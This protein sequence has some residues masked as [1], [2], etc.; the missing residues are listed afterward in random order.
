MTRRW[1]LPALLLGLAIAM[2]AL[3]RLTEDTV[4]PAAAAPPAVPPASRPLAVTATG[5]ANPAAPA[6]ELRLGN[7]VVVMDT[8]H[9]VLRAQLALSLRLPSQT[10]E[11]QGSVQV[12]G[13]P[14]L[15]SGG[16]R[17]Y[18]DKPVR[19]E[20]SLPGLPAAESARVLAALDR[21]IPAFFQQ[22][23]VFAP[24]E[25]ALTVPPLHQ[26]LE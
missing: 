21:A 7:P 10:Q 16:Q 2:T 5:T 9:A 19:G 3:F 25:P 17:F 11:W 1:G 13:P 6:G 8:E 22:R 18:L 15:D 26:P 20:V 24:A 14:R 12:S 23:P 4:P